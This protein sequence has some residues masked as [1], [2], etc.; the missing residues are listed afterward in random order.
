MVSASLPVKTSLV[1]SGK[2]TSTDGSSLGLGDV[3]DPQ[4]GLDVKRLL[5]DGDQ[6]KVAVIT[7]L[8]C[9]N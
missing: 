9:V 3:G 6:R 1:P 8:L 4:A 2:K 7:A 5:F